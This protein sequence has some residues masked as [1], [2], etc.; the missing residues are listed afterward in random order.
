MSGPMEAGENRGAGGGSAGS[1]NNGLAK[2]LFWFALP[3]ILS[4]LL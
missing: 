1:R 4:G 2:E 3:L